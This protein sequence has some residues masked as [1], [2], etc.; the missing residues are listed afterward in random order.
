[1]SDPDAHGFQPVPEANRPGHHP[2]VEQDRPDLDAFAARLGVPPADPPDGGDDDVL[3]PTISLESRRRSRTV[4]RA[5]AAHPTAP[6]R[7]DAGA[8]RAGAGPIHIAPVSPVDPASLVAGGVGVALRT[9]THIAVFPLRFTAASLRLVAKLMGR[10]AER[11]HIVAVRSQP[12][13]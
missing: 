9:A 5:V 11:R 1:M 3:A 8:L 4:E 10:Q 13:G 12:Q 2:D 6:R 7:D